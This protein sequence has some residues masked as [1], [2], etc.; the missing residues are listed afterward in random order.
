MNLFKTL[1]VAT[2]LLTFSGS[3]MANEVE[4]NKPLALA[5]SCPEGCESCWDQCTKSDD[6]GSGHKCI[7]GSCGNRCVKE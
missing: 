2:T 5:A 7:S 3:G 6:C 4:K 1:I